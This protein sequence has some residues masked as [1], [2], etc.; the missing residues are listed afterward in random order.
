MRILLSYSFNIFFPWFPFNHFRSFFKIYLQ[1]ILYILIC[2]AY[3]Y[4]V[5]FLAWYSLLSFHVLNLRTPNLSTFVFRAATFRVL[6]KSIS[7][8]R[9][10]NTVVLFSTAVRF[11]FS[12]TFE[13]IFLCEVGVEAHYPPPPHIGI[14]LI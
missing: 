7:L 5:L 9:G 8:T 13:L 12:S 11:T 10:H 1:E 6:V 4:S 2:I 14:Q 3:I